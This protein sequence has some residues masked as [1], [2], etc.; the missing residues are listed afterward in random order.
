MEAE[1]GPDLAIAAARELGRPLTL[2]GPVTDR[3]FFAREVEPNLGDGIDY[4]GVLGHP[5]K[6]RLLGD[7]SC[8]VMP[9][10][11]AEPFGLVAVEAMACGTPVAALP[12]GALA[13]VVEPGVTGALADAEAALAQ[14]IRR[15]EGLDREAVR[16]RA[17]ER[18]G[19][20]G[21]AQRYLEVYAEALA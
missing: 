9:S 8:A 21:V 3:E 4:A 12:S 10:R 13:E 15:A 18:F 1:K 5:E 16:R 20:A 17:G 11:W 19:I 6:T 7:A 14:A 2:A